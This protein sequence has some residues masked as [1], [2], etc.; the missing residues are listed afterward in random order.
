MASQAMFSLYV[1]VIKW[2]HTTRTNVFVKYYIR[3]YLSPRDEETNPKAKG[4]DIKLK[5]RKKTSSKAGREVTSVHRIIR[6][7]QKTLHR[8]SSV[9]SRRRPQPWVYTGS[10]DD[11]HVLH[12]SISPVSSF[13][14]T[15]LD[16]VTPDYPMMKKVLHRSISPV[17][18]ISGLSWTK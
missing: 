12:R 11:E 5:R 3:R 15:I 6:C 8:S 9:W 18:S 13:F 2:Q 16:Q 4:E 7:I 14:W 1:L 17:S 10:S